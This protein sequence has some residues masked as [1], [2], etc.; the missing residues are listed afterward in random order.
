MCWTEHLESLHT[1]IELLV[2][3]INILT[4]LIVEKEEGNKS[5]RFQR[6]YRYRLLYYDFAV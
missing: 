2:K 3:G 6:Q 1:S 5:F 4:F